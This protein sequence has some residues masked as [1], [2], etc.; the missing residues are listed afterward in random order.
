MGSLNV[1]VFTK[2]DYDKSLIKYRQATDVTQN[3]AEYIP[4]MCQDIIDIAEMYKKLVTEYLTSDEWVDQAIN[5]AGTANDTSESLKGTSIRL[6]T[7]VKGMM[8]SIETDNRRLK[9]TMEDKRNQLDGILN[10]LTAINPGKV[11]PPTKSETPTNEEKPTEE[12]P[13]EEQPPVEET[14]VEET[15]VEETPTEE[16]NPTPT[17]DTPPAETPA[18]EPPA[19]ETPPA[20]TGTEATGNKDIETLR[21][22]LGLY[23]GTNGNANI[24][25]KFGYYDEGLTN[26]Q[27]QLLNSLDTFGSSVGLTQQQKSD[28]AYIIGRESGFKTSATNGSHWGIGQLTAGNI[29]TYASD[30]TAYYNGDSNV[31]I[32]ATY[33]YILDRYGSIENARAF[34]DSHGWY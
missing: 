22:E 28:W 27:T 16:T 13:T 3:I 25:N 10:T 24:N 23:D 19:P 1:D 26:Q 8:D 12:T 34:W 18:A 9:S 15:P 20:P 21:Q 5:I 4:T 30:P 2:K 31:Q 17:E 32:N 6:V 14:P 11:T 7:D 33:N 29:E